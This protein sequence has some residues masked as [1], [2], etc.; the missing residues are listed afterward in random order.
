MED[1]GALMGP[2]L[3]LGH[4]FAR[5][6]I[7]AP[8]HHLIELNQAVADW[9]VALA[10]AVALGGAPGVR[11]LPCDPSNVSNNGWGKPP[12]MTAIN[13]WS[14]M[15]SSRVSSRSTACTGRPSNRSK[16]SLIA[17]R[18]PPSALFSNFSTIMRRRRPPPVNP[19]TRSKLRTGL[20]L[21]CR[22]DWPA[23]IPPPRRLKVQA[24]PRRNYDAMGG[25]ARD[26]LQTSCNAA[27]RPTCLR[28]VHLKAM[29]LRAMS[30]EPHP[31]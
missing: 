28:K 25:V 4:D 17:C 6:L 3:T 23:H 10:F 18:S 30:R 22:S 31:S 12:R 19:A 14:V 9:G 15:S 5:L 27:A 24:K 20:S 26:T 7:S 11:I 1:N 2:G 16:I 21:I 29:A 8:G 13:C